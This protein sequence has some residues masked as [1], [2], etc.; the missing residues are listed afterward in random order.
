MEV[1]RL[2]D[3]SPQRR[4]QLL[5]R[6]ADLAEISDDVA[7][8]IDRVRTDGDEAVRAFAEEFDEVDDPTIDITDAVTGTADDLES[9]TRSAIETA[10]AN[11]RAFHD[12]QRPTDWETTEGGRTLGRRF[13]P[14]DRVGVYVPGGTAAYPSTALMGVIPAVVAGVE[15]VV[16]A[17]P[18]ADGTHPATSAA[19]EIAGA[20]EVYAVGGA[21]AI[22]A[23]AYGTDTIDPVEK[24]VGP[25]NK[26]VTAAK[27][28]VRGDVAIDFLAGP[29][30]ILVVAD[31]TAVPE[32]VA[33]DLIAQ[34]EHD[35][36]ASAVA[37]TPDADIATATAREIE[38]QLPDRDRASIAEQA[39]TNPTSG[40][41][42]ADNLD[43]AIGFAEAYAPEHLSIQTETPEPVLDRI[44]SAGSVFLGSMTPVAAGDY[45]TG[46]NH[47]LPTGGG[48]KVRGGL[49][50]ESF[51]RA[52]TVQQ[53]DED[54]VRSL[55]ETITTLATKEGLEAHAASIDAR[56]DD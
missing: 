48:V 9:E 31:H 29:S 13:R 53:L 17:T 16:V 33:A 46:T 3:L 15:E 54:G 38:T 43:E 30:E 42:H 19:I 39:L 34:A 22:A 5:D 14:I 44:P 41:F 1:S 51:L 55:R 26:W 37:V 25:G 11:I 24:I 56:F 49:A 50:V 35:P 20:D 8:I 36:H 7:T 4:A 10:A 18:P 21:Q 6:G 32:H 28:A 52:T 12:A 45:A 47:I 2:G 40:V 27:A 23:L